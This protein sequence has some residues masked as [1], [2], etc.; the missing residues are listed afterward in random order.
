MRSTPLVC[1]LD[2]RAASDVPE[3]GENRGMTSSTMGR[4]WPASLIVVAALAGAAA[5]TPTQAPSQHGSQAPAPAASIVVRPDGR[6]D[7]SAPPAGAVMRYTLDGTD[8]T[9]DAGEWLAPVRV[10]PGYTREGARRLPQ[11]ARPSGAVATWSAPPAGQRQPSTLVPVTQNRDWRVYDW[12]TRTPRGVSADADA[13][14]GHRHARRFD[15]AFLGRRAGRRPPH[16]RRRVGSLLRRP[17]ASST[18]ATGG[19]APRTS[20]GVSRTASSRA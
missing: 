4:L 3:M 12:T 17:H 7:V 5:Q 19:I 13:P 11:T 10:P 20:S 18:S 9:R 8:P 15:H 6:L 14:A 16:R 1:Q 2:V